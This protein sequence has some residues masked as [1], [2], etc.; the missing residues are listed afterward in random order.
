LVF[1][2]VC[3]GFSCNEFIAFRYTTASFVPKRPQDGDA[4]SLQPGR[5]RVRNIQRPRGE[6][7]CISAVA[8]MVARG[9][10][11]R[12]PLVM[13]SASPF[14]ESRT[15]PSPTRGA[16]HPVSTPSPRFKGGLVRYCLIARAT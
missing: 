15:V 6:R 1:L 8:F 3:H 7:H 12:R 9:G 4:L 11:D 10:F 5:R 2:V 16:R 14:D 13:R